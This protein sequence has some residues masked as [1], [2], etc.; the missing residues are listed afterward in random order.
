MS[1]FFRPTQQAANVIALVAAHDADIRDC[2][3][4][5]GGNGTLEPR[6]FLSAL[7]AQCTSAK[8]ALSPA[9][10]HT[11]LWAL[12]ILCGHTQSRDRPPQFEIVK[13]CMPL[14]SSMLTPG[15][16]DETVVFSALTAVSALL[17]QYD[18]ATLSPLFEAIVK[19]L[20]DA[21]AVGETQTL[22]KRSVRVQRAAMTCVSE[23]AA[24][25]TGSIKGLVGYKDGNK[26]RLLSVLPKLLWS[27]D[28]ALRLSAAQFAVQCLPQGFAAEIVGSDIVK[29]MTRL[30]STD[31]AVRGMAARFFRELCKILLPQQLVDLV[32]RGMVKMLSMNFAHL[33]LFMR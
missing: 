10:V 32:H 26:S 25:N 21:P 17:P 11:S 6:P 33:T 15:V 22:V 14:F 31:D 30:L 3:L 16:N 8:F 24:T 9:V 5:F 19:L 4:A 13:I 23:V 18:H 1:L 12:A 29:E 27:G 20:D 7:A 2:F 28:V